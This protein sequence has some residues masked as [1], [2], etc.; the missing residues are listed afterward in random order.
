MNIRTNRTLPQ[1]PSVLVLTDYYP[2]KHLIGEMALLLNQDWGAIVTDKFL[3]A[4]ELGLTERNLFKTVLN[5][6]SIRDVR[7]LDEQK[8]AAEFANYRLLVWNYFPFLRGGFEC[9][10]MSGLPQNNCDWILYCDE[11][12]ADF[13]KCVDAYRIILAMN[14]EVKAARVLC[15]KK[16]KSTLQQS[17]DSGK[18][19]CRDFSHP[20]S[21]T[22]AFEKKSAEFRDIL[23]G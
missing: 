19:V 13:L 22:S 14:G 11:R 23:K 16:S 9:E 5:R 8:I 10:G 15:L 18:Y 20:R 17:I 4:K 12:L 2:L 1:K 3:S 7:E 21:W 6:T